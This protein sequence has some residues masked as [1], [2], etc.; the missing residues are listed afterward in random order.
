M[1]ACTD[2]N[3]QVCI[4]QEHNTLNAHL[5]NLI[6]FNLL[7]IFYFNT[8]ARCAASNEA[9]FSLP[10]RFCNIFFATNSLLVLFMVKFFSSSVISA[11]VVSSSARPGQDVVVHDNPLKA[12]IVQ[13]EEQNANRQNQNCVATQ[14]EVQN[15]VDNINVVGDAEADVHKVENRTAKAAEQAMQ[16]IKFRRNEFKQELNGLGNTSNKAGAGTGNHKRFYLGFLVFLRALIHSKAGAG[17]T[18]QEYRIQ[19]G[20]E[21]TRSGVA[22]QEARNITHNYIAGCIGE[23]THLEP[24]IAVDDMVQTDGDQ[25]TVQETKQ[26]NTNHARASHPHCQA[27]KAVLNRWPYNVKQ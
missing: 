14:I 6:C 15:I 8:Q 17:Q 19:T 21:D 26:E 16:Q 25:C 20:H 3:L 5:A 11:V 24:Q 18:K 1:Y 2:N 9:I 10:P 23:R 4:R 27:V 13:E 7:G 22:S 12:E